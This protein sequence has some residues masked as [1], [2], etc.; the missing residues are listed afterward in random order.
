MKI[1]LMNGPPQSG[2]DTA[3]RLLAQMLH[4]SV[5]LKFAEPLKMAT[6]AAM[7][8]LTSGSN[9][10]FSEGYNDCKDTPSE[11]FLGLTPRLAY[12]AMS[13]RYIKP[14]LG[15]EFLGLHLVQRIKKHQEKGIEHVVITDSGFHEELEPLKKEFGHD[16]I[17]VIKIL[18]PGTH[19]GAD[20]RGYLTDSGVN[21]ETLSNDEDTKDLRIKVAELVGRLEQDE[22]EVVEL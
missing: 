7:A 9:I 17:C 15:K 19:F 1:Y 10:K 11:D 14:L 12:I 2:K 22:Q 8:M 5:V 6:H 20:S 18:R 21:Y 13:E 4:K 3:G 16:A